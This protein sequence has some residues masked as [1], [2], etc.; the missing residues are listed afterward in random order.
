M[1]R[2]EDRGDIPRG[3]EYDDRWAR[4]AARGESIHGE[5][6]LVASLVPPG[7]SVLD[8]GCG[9]GR[10]AIELARRGHDVVGIDLDP[11]MLDLARDKAPDKPWIQGDLA[12]TVV[13]D[14]AGERRLFDA[15]IAAGNVMIFL[16]RGTEAAVVANIAAHLR[17]GGVLVAGFQLSDGYMQL[18]VYDALAQRNG[19][20]LVA[21]YSTWEGAPFDG[22]DYAVS[23]HRR[24]AATTHS[25]G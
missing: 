17:P 12:S 25:G 13:F 4:M 3:T 15:V 19:L 2:W 16:E 23:V 21:R 11:A 24:A 5:A 20:E 1:S 22:G 8:A 9:T 10:V 18:H 6:D 7:G 14:A